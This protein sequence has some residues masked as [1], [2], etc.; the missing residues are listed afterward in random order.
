MAYLE[1]KS[2]IH[3]DL[4]ARNCLI[5]ANEEAKIADFGLSRNIKSCF[6]VWYYNNVSIIIIVGGSAKPTIP[7]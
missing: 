4:A 1:K 3:R 5:A 7:I 2:F 6:K